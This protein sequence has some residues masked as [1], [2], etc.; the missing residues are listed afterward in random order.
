[1]TYECVRGV[2]WGS[3]TAHKRWREWVYGHRFGWVH[4]CVF[5]L[6][7]FLPFGLVDLAVFNMA[8]LGN[9]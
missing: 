7:I 1:M 8:G 5:I 4:L 2:V 3:K 6:F 9:L